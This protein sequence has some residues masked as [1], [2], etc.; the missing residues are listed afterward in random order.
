MANK[1]KEEKHLR[2]ELP[3]N[4]EAEKA[5]LGAMIRS[6]EKLHEGFG[7]LTVDDFFEDNLSHR[8][9]FSAMKRLDDRGEPI[10]I[11]TLVNEL[12]NANEIEVSG[13]ADYLLELTDAV[14]IFS[15]FRQYAT[16]VSQQALLRK[17]LLTIDEINDKYYS[18]DIGDVTTFL[19]DADKKLREIAEKRA[20]GDFFTAKQLSAS[21]EK[22]F[23]D[24][25]EAISDDT[26]LGTPTGYQSLNRM[27]HGFKPGEFIVLAARTGAGKTTLALNLAYNAAVRDRPVAYFSLEM[28][29]N[30]LVKRILS[31]ES[32]IPYDSLITGFGL[33]RGDT[34]LKLKQACD[35]FSTIKFYVD[36][37]SG[38]QLNDLVAKVRTLYNKEPDLGLIVV[39]HIG[40]VASGL[41]RP[42]SRQL[43]VQYISQTLK[44]LALEI[45]VPIIGVTQLNRD[46]EKR[47]G[48][49]PV[50]ADLRESGS[51]EQDADIVLLIYEPKDGDEKKSNNLF[52]KNASEVDALA[53]KAVKNE[54][55]P[56]VTVVNLIV[57]K[58]RQG[59]KGTI[60]LLFRKKYYKFDSPSTEKEEEIAKINSERIKMFSRD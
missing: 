27:T 39:D 40:L 33:N 22:E 34:R 58:N 28:P 12:I 38:I 37:T 45:K 49:I 56:E 20:V 46:V 15:N 21:L 6:K 1:K 60:P 11:Q 10:D 17:Y 16:M 51:I 7:L 29:A 47:P 9:I 32:N 24:L 41:K 8:A 48:G 18:G 57:A 2:S 30:D 25:K 23:N 35:R 54:A 5:V 31:G 19:G 50:I 44:K 59:K 55:G 43:E 26:V 42:D 13:G 52:D 53:N 14:I 3:H 36:E 4:T